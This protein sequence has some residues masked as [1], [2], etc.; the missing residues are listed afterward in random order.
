MS[1]NPAFKFA[2]SFIYSPE[3]FPACAFTNETDSLIWNLNREDVYS[4]LINDVIT[5]KLDGTIDK[6]PRIV[7]VAWSPENLIYPSQCMLAILSSAGAVELLHKVSNNWYS[8]CDVSSIRLKMVQ[9]KIKTNL[10]KCKRSTIQSARIAEDIRKLQACS[11]MWSKLLKFE[12]TFFAYFSVAYYSGDILIW[13]IPRLSNFTKSLELV[14]A[15]TIH[16]N[17]ASKANVSCWITINVNEHLIVIGYFDGSVHGIKLTDRN[18]DL[19]VASMEKYVNPDRIAV[20]YLYIISQ[21]DPDIKILAAKGSFLLLLC[22][23]SA[24]ELKSIRHLRVQG[25]NITGEDYS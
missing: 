22:V 10:K 25:C 8:I 17:N 16:L 19:Q 23:N 13:K 20:N 12:E 15:G 7:N 18:N 2:R 14:F 21:D 3:I 11:V 4:V 5:P 1:P 6:F 9:D 24:G